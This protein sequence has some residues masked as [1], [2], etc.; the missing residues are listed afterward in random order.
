MRRFVIGLALVALAG[1]GVMA[2]QGGAPDVDKTYTS[3]ADVQGLIATAQA[4]LKPDQAQGGGRILHL[5]P[6][7][8]N[9]EYRRAGAGLPPQGAA[10]HETEAEVFYVIDG[11]GVMTTGGKLVNEK[12]TNPTNLS[13][14]QQSKAARTRRWPRATG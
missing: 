14:G 5:A 8:A 7:N 11:S 12:R 9:L 6:Y 4:A 2:Q 13:W 10:V 1:A 3:A